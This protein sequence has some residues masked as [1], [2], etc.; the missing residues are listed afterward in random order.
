MRCARLVTVLALAV[1]PQHMIMFHYPRWSPDGAS[2]V[3]TTNIDGDD[4]EV[5]VVSL[6]GKQRRKLTDN[7]VADTGADW[8]ADGRRI[9][10]QRHSGSAVEHVV[11]NADGSSVEKYA[12]PRPGAV[13]GITVEE[14]QTADGQAVMLKKDGQ[15]ERRVN[16]VAWA[17]QP[18]VSP[19]G[20]LVVFEQRE[21]Q[22]DILSSDI[23]VW[24]TRTE[25]VRV[26]ARGTDPSW[27]PDGRLL[28]FK[29]PRATDN[30]LFIALADVATGRVRLLA[31]G[32]HP[33]FSPDG[34]QI[35]F[36][37]DRPDRA[38]VYVIGTDGRGQ[39]CVTCSWV[40]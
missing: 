30:A 29:T 3:L 4:E 2:L 7:A 1:A 18:S 22:H 13:A 28:L 11:M 20:T 9:V 23:A 40:R 32:V 16:R 33:H 27:S 5:W 37:A 35:A 25:E 26:I 24:D 17:E 36:M 12:P 10:F 39:Y 14:R 6:D 15:T 34:K 8:L 31:P 19:D 21:R 38:D